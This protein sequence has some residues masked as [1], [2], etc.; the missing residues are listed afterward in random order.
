MVLL[1]S[2]KLEIGACSIKFKEVD[3]LRRAEIGP[4]FCKSSSTTARAPST[5]TLVK[6]K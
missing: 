2:S 6:K 4:T 5:G 1:I 3:K